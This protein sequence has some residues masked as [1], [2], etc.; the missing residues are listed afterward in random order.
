MVEVAVNDSMRFFLEMVGERSL[1]HVKASD[2][3]HLN[4]INDVLQV[5]LLP[6]SLLLRAR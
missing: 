2:K 3:V 4:L 5:A 1:D 6:G